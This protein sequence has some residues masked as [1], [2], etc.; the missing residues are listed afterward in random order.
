[1]T[2]TASE[3][4]DCRN[5]ELIETTSGHPLCG[6]TLMKWPTTTHGLPP[7]ELIELGILSLAL[8]LAVTAGFIA[9]LGAAN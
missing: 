9:L 2:L 4:L 7:A 8:S 5:A 3:D 1:M 6:S